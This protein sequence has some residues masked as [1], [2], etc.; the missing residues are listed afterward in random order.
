MQDA[1][2][3]VALGLAAPPAAH[4]S[5]AYGGITGGRAQALVALVVGLISVVIGGLA[6]ARSARVAGAARPR[7][8]AT[9]DA[10]PSQVSVSDGPGDAAR[11]RSIAVATNSSYLALALG[12][13]GAVLGAVRLASSTAIGTGSGR[14]GAIVALA[15][16][17]VGTVLGGLALARSR[18]AA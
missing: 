17:L 7:G 16:G 13:V 18:R 12:L 8:R 4:V 2:V 5:I 1:L 15:V 11:I 14:L 10:A 3:S 9:D 6:L